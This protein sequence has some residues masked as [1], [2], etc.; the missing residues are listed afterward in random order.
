MLMETVHNYRTT[1]D[2][3]SECQHLIIIIMHM[4]QRDF[5]LILDHWMDQ[6]ESVHPHSHI[7]LQ[8]SKY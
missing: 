6:V 4:S 8:C 3:P 5:A 1:G 7:S 2:L